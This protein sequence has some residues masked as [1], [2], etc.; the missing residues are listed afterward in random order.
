MLVWAAFVAVRVCRA[1]V[2]VVYE[3]GVCLL[4][5]SRR[6]KPNVAADALCCCGRA[7]TGCSL[8]APVKVGGHLAQLR[9]VQQRRRRGGV[10]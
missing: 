4:A 2:L 10:W 1:V 9:N 5:L 3:H 7:W 6:R 8:E